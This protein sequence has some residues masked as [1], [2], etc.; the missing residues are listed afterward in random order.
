VS[1]AGVGIWARRP[2]L[3]RRD[4]VGEVTYE[5]R[6][7]WP[8]NVLLVLGL[9]LAA[10]GLGAE[11]ADR[12]SAIGVCALY[13]RLRPGMS[14]GAVE[15]LSERAARLTTGAPVPTWLLWR[16]AGPDRGTEVL[17]ASFR[18]GRL[19]RIEYESF[20][21]EYQHF[22]KDDRTG[23]MEADEV[24]RLWRRAAQVDP[25]AERCHEALDAFHQLVV[26]VQERLTTN[27]QREWVRA[28]ELRRAAEAEL[29]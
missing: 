11:P 2:F 13:Q 24:P 25:A 1:R 15:A 22:V 20:R 12:G 6:D 16:H 4:T 3:A 29:P 9:S 23:P 21:D 14:V 26:R 18:E 28:L 7:A 8:I 5:Q 10:S 19:A 27:E 17:R